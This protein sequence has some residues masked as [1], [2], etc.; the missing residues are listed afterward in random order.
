MLASP[1]TIGN[2]LVQTRA[3]RQNLKLSVMH[4]TPPP[5]LTIIWMQPSL[6]S[7]G[8]LAPTIIAV[9]DTPIE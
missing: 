1:A 7:Q 4:L 8:E 2:A 6:C 9:C 5:L 3:V